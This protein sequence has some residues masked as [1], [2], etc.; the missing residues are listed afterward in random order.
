MLP[1]NLSLSMDVASSETLYVGTVR[2]S[3]ALGGQAIVSKPAPASPNSILTAK[4]KGVL[5]FMFSCRPIYSFVV[6]AWFGF[7]DSEVGF[8]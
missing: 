8:A 2:G 5:E 3:E 1:D 6:M 7:F 4:V